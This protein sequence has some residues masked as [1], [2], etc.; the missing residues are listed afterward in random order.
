MLLKPIARPAGP[1]GASGRA[2]GLRRRIFQG[3]CGLG[4]LLLQP[5]CASGDPVRLRVR[6]AGVT[7]FEHVWQG[8]PL[9]GTDVDLGPLGPGQSSRWHAFPA[10]PSHY[11]KTAVQLE[12]GS[13]LIFVNEV[14]FPQRKTTLEPG[15]YTFEYRL[16]GG[17]LQLRV[18]EEGRGA[19]A[20]PTH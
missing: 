9:Q 13:Q 11:R 8:S 2:G 5:A 10:H 14:A 19:P 7:T 3:L 1:A 20:A 16:D 4:L 17:R 15:W 12:G 18:I 6:N